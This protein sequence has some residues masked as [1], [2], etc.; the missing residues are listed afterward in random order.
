MIPGQC[1]IGQ[2]A[3]YRLATR[4]DGGASAYSAWRQIGTALQAPTVTDARYVNGGAQVT[5]TAPIPT[6]NTVR[7]FYYQIS[8]KGDGYANS[9]SSTTATSSPLVIPGQCSIGQTA[10]YRLATRVDGG[11]SAYSAWRQ[12]GTAL[13][14]PTVTDARYVNGGAQ[15]TFT[16]PIPTG[17]TVRGFYYRI[18]CKGDGYANSRSS[19]TATSSPLVIPGQC[20]IGQT[21]SYR[22]ATRVDGCA[23]A[24]SGPGDKSA[25]PCKH[26][27]S[28]ARRW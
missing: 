23:S 6:G 28:S 24:D 8:C 4:V 13:Q 5:F 26:L 27:S 20:S 9:S 1:S 25:P 18:P 12:I 14:A 7:G 22:L 10:S 3:S 16:A 11:A 2:T 19:T 21:A 17:N 15:V